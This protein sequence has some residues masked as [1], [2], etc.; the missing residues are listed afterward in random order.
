MLG[1]MRQP[2]DGDRFAR[3]ASL[4][5]AVDTLAPMQGLM[6]AAGLIMTTPREEQRAALGAAGVALVPS[7]ESMLG[8]SPGNRVAV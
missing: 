6:R 2:L 5:A 3:A 7:D 4:L 8:T 1:M